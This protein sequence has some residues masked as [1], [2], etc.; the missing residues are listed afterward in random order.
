MWKVLMVKTLLV[1]LVTGFSVLAADSLHTMTA[2][3]TLPGAGEIGG[4]FVAQARG[5]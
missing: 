1:V 2:P 5:H 4:D 3:E